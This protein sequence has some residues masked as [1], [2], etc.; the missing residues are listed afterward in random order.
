M[1]YWQVLFTGTTWDE[2]RDAGATTSGFNARQRNTVER[3]KSGD[4][5]LG[6][7]TGVQHWVGPF[8]SLAPAMTSGAFGAMPSSRYGWQL[9][10]W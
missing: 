7:L 5:L 1:N 3:I 10:Q 9:S 8:G 4:V 2:F 6:Y